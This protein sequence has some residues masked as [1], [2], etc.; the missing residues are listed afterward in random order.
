MKNMKF[1]DSIKKMCYSKNTVA[2]KKVEGKPE[3]NCGCCCCGHDSKENKS[4][5]Q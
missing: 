5:K 1:L 2:N 4:K 3:D